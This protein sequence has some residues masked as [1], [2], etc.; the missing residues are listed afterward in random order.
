MC[1]LV[2][3]RLVAALIVG[4]KLAASKS[5]KSCANREHCS[6]KYHTCY[7]IGAAS[8]H[9]FLLNITS[10]QHNYLQDS[11]LLCCPCWGLPNQEL[12]SRPVAN[13]P[14]PSSGNIQIWRTSIH[15]RHMA[16]ICTDTQHALLMDTSCQLLSQLREN[17]E[18]EGNGSNAKLLLYVAQ[19]K[20]KHESSN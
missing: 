6:K 14:S 5:G 19:F 2:S 3:T 1:L 10:G 12:P 11:G 7:T 4:A 16:N 9:A 13:C 17:R 20:I 18:R 8:L 15:L